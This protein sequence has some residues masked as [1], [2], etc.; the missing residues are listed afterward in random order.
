MAPV[1]ND[2]ELKS[3]RLRKLF[4]AITDGK[5][6]VKNSND[7]KL[8]LEAICDQQDRSSCIERLVASPQGLQALRMSLRSDVSSTCIN[9]SSGNMLTY[10]AHD[11]VRQLCSGQLMQDILVAVLQPPTFWNAL[12]KCYDERTLSPSGIHAFACLLLEVLSS[13]PSLLP[14]NTYDIAGKALDTGGLLESSNTDTR[15]LAYKIQDAVRCKAS[16]GTLPGTIKPGGRHDNDFEDFRKIS[17]FPTMDEFL[18]K[19]QPFYLQSD[20]VFETEP[21]KRAAVHLDN[22]F[23]LLREDM[24][25]ELRNDLKIAGGSKQ[26]RRV[27]LRLKS[28]VFHGVDCGI[29]KKRKQA[30][31][32]LRCYQGLP[33][34]SGMAQ[35]QRKKHYA[36]NRTFLK[37]MSFGCLLCSEDIVA[38]ATIDRNEDL[39]AEDPPII[40]L[41]IF[42]DSALMKALISLKTIHQQNIEFVQVD[43]PFFAYEP[44]LKC[45][46]EKTSLPLSNELLGLVEPGQITKSPIVPEKIVSKIKRYQGHNLRDLLHLPIDV[47]LDRSQT[48]SL[49]AGLSQ[50]LSLI[51]GPPGKIRSSNA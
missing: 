15:S 20:A 43:T 25:A 14:S 47:I 11:S 16:G 41:Q 32:A 27:S 5:R 12:E 22:Q 28:L 46:Q 49:V 8:F 33:K 29:E 44:I 39:L 35:T 18:A 30:T 26:G 31:I 7:A 3:N 2:I 23:R 21:E 37:H 42:G 13:P 6:A 1:E 45:L 24:L 17:V 36:D 51:Q 4:T 19:K 48:E 50:S 10:I 40:L 34:L 38:F 9:E